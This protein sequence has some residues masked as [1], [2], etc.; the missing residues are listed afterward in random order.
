LIIGLNATCLNDRPSGAKQRFV[1]IYSGLIKSFPKARFIIYEP[2]DSNISSWFVNS[3]NITYI[4]T[5]IPSEGRIVK[6]LFSILYFKNEF[7]KKK[8]DIFE[9]F[10]LPFM[11]P[12][13]GI[14]F[15]TIHD[16]RGMLPSSKLSEKILH[17]LSLAKAINDTDH[18]I[19]VSQAMRQE[20]L[21]FFPEISL[22]VIYN[23]I[24]LYNRENIS[25]EELIKFQKK[26]NIND[27]FI[28]A[29][30]H[31]ETR[32]N[33]T[34]LIQAFSILK[35]KGFDYKLIIIGNDSGEKSK[36]QLLINQLN[37]QEQV[38]FLSGLSDSEVLC[39]YKLCSLFV[40]PS[41]YEGFGIP[42]LEAMAASR[43]I[44]LSDLP[45][46]REITQ[47]S[48][49][50]F[51]PENIKSI[52][53]SI[54]MVLKSKIKQEKIINYGNERINSFDYKNLTSQLVELYNS[55]KK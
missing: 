9:G 26:H 16:I 54:E 49:V 39:A 35:N 48:G 40:F 51:D 23:G 3:E 22:S 25:E 4:R 28:L 24:D 2:K 36:L 46:F 7:R 41:L 31:I 10:H 17:K 19:T 55:Y 30:G 34:R 6:F 18:I 14:K 20:I 29:V 12:S 43:P 32:K 42:I 33:Y 13:S 52:V 8:F 15:L 50:Y 1:G 5:P 27:K 44:V 38:N 47:N 37:L 53:N 21:K 11:K 45:V